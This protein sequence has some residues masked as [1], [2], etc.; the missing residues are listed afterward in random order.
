MP[1]LATVPETAPPSEKRLASVLEHKFFLRLHMTAILTATILVGLATTR[2]LFL[3][4]VNIFWIRY[5]LAG[6]GGR[7]AGRN[8]ARQHA[9]AEDLIFFVVEVFLE[10]G[11]RRRKRRPR[12]ADSDRADHRPGCGDRRVVRL[13]GLGGTRNLERDGVQCG[14]SRRAYASRA[15]SGA[16]KL[17]R[18]RDEKDDAAVRA[19]SGS[20][21]CC[22]CLGPALL[23]YRDPPARRVALRESLK[24]RPLTR[25]SATLSPL[26]GARD[27][28]E[29]PRGIVVLTT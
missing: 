10:V 12:R 29:E 4:H 27:D 22:R 1:M 6:G 25:P 7:S 9:S 14:A 18:Q 16:G 24:L 5:E 8:G 15:Q 11:G 26:R 28:V 19:D 20:I 2:G 21:D 3:L 17:D 23:P 13:A